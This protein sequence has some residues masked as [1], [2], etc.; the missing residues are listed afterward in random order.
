MQAF[1]IE[2]DLQCA[3]GAAGGVQHGETLFQKLHGIGDLICGIAELFFELFNAGVQ[4]GD[5]AVCGIDLLL[6]GINLFGEQGK[7][8]GLIGLLRLQRGDFVFEVGLFVGELGL[9]G[10]HIGYGIVSVAERC[11]TEQQ[12]GKHGC[13]DAL[14]VFR[15]QLQRKNFLSAIN[16]DFIKGH[17][18][19]LLYT[20][21]FYMITSDF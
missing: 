4:H 16:F 11:G 17:T 9:L 14:H 13:S 7:V 2:E 12:G 1:G 8:F 10:F 18:N 3:D 6:D 5:V 20:G 15:K 19:P 21:L